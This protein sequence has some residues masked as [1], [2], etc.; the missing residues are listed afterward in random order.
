[1]INI[2]KNTLS[3]NKLTLLSESFHI[4]EAF[5]S[6]G[7]G[8]VEEKEHKVYLVGK[9]LTFGKPTR[10][11]VAYTHESGL[12][13]LSSW[14]GRPFLNSH[15]DDDVL[16]TI[17]HV[18]KMEIRPDNE[19]RNSLFY[20]VDIDPTE[21]K[22][23]RK[24]KRGDIPFVSVQVL[25]SD[26]R[27]KETMEFGNFIEAD[28]KEGLEL[29]SVLIPGER[30]TNG[31]ITEERFAE[32]FLNK[33]EEYPDPVADIKRDS[34]PVTKKGDIV[35]P[36]AAIVP[37][38]PTVQEDISTNVGDGLI[39]EEDE[40]KKIKKV[41][42]PKN[43]ITPDLIPRRM[44]SMQ[45]LDTEYQKKTN[46]AG[47][48]QEEQ[49]ADYKYDGK[50]AVKYYKKGG[51]NIPAVPLKGY[52]AE[53]ISAIIECCGKPMFVMKNSANNIALLC[54]RCGKNIVKNEKFWKDTNTYIKEKLKN[55]EDSQMENINRQPVVQQAPIQ[56]A[57]VQAPIQQVPAQPVQQAPVGQAIPG[58]V[59]ASPVPSTTPEYEQILVKLQELEQR[60]GE[61]EMQNA[62]QTVQA[63][64]GKFEKMEKK[65]EEI[66]G[67]PEL[68]KKQQPSKQIGPEGT[69]EIPKAQTSEID[70]EDGG[71]K[72]GAPVAGEETG[73]DKG[74]PSE[75]DAIAKVPKPKK[76]LPKF[77]IIKNAL[78]GADGGVPVPG[79]PSKTPNKM[80]DE[81]G[82]K[83]PK[84]TSDGFEE[85][86]LEE[87]YN[88]I[89]EKLQGRKS[90]VGAFASSEAESFS[91]T[92]DDT[93]SVIKE[94]LRKS[95]VRI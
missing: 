61:Q 43:K 13:S 80:E 29:S 2:P 22:F 56:Q 57:P 68:V 38:N 24:A 1:M 73:L 52:K 5:A 4:E 82:N 49:E 92:R 21:E 67:E 11:K 9:A 44:I 55:K 69:N 40:A 37:V 58:Q 26:V 31:Y 89:K 36:N 71:T 48:T 53:N 34:K 32:S 65:K 79:K 10:N 35:H 90:T 25:V 87:H 19:G 93:N 30:E 59:P 84:N 75:D 95:K 77:P 62:N 41:E 7:T 18:E 70:Y 20:K 54:E 33:K 23:I 3:S 60:V 27:Q 78:E 50:P 6:A 86:S 45:N 76:E 42:E 88:Y 17:G 14:E 46:V 12:A 16:S 74:E 94:Y 39:Q 91:N 83:M 72:D 81:E 47:E 28:I 64:E 66:T 8:D 85:K 51:N 63:D 15:K